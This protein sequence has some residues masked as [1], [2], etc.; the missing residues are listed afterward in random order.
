MH[1]HSLLTGKRI[2]RTNPLCDDDR[3]V[4]RDWTR[5]EHL[6]AM[7]RLLHAADRNS[8]TPRG[9]LLRAADLHVQAAKSAPPADTTDG[10]A[11]PENRPRTN[12]DSPPRAGQ[13]R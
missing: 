11:A 13:R 10:L 12:P 8:N 9:D 6:A 5:E 1:H 4:R 2:D 3:D 7:R